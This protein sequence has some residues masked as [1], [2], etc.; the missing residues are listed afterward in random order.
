MTEVIPSI[1]ALLRILSLRLLKTKNMIYIE[2]SLEKFKNLPLEVILT[3]DNDKIADI[4]DELGTAHKV[5]LYSLLI[6]LSVGDMREE[7]IPEYL[8]REFGLSN[9]AI[10]R[11]VSEFKERVLSKLENR[12]NFLSDGFDR[13]IGL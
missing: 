12:L 3:I 13:Q 4:L 11:V 2:E 10:K 8:K 5:N 9:I 7:D 6:F 1:E